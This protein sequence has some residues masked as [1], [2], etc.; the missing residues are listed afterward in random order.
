MSLSVQETV[1]SDLLDLSDTPLAEVADTVSSDIGDI[2]RRAMPLS[3][4][5]ERPAVSAFNS[6]I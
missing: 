4:D 6:S 2:I 1:M 3:A 5:P